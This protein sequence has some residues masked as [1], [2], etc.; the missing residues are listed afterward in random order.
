ML[1]HGR[2]EVFPVTYSNG[3]QPS[4]IGED[5][6]GES[7][8]TTLKDQ[9]LEVDTISE[10]RMVHMS[11]GLADAKGVQVVASMKHENRQRVFAKEEANPIDRIGHFL[12]HYEIATHRIVA[13]QV[14]EH[15]VVHAA[16]VVFY[17]FR[18]RDTL[19]PHLGR[20]DRFQRREDGENGVLTPRSV[21]R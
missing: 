12:V 8:I 5:A 13:F 3:F 2:F 19:L 7:H 15:L 18:L 10:T 21:L 11:D 16:Q 4:C 14:G 1:E 17:C 20:S 9:V 6:F